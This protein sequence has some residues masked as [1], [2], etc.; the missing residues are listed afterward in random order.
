M[1]AVKCRTHD[2]RI[3][4][5]EVFDL[6]AAVFLVSCLAS[7]SRLTWYGQTGVQLLLYCR[8]ASAVA[9]WQRATGMRSGTP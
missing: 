7:H 9:C 8:L 1:E 5:K 3:G 6:A 2:D 4:L